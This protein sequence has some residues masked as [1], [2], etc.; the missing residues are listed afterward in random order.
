MTSIN[1]H[2]IFFDAPTPIL[3]GFGAVIGL[4]VGSFV[5]NTA[6]RSVRG[7]SNLPGRSI[8]DQCHVALR[9]HEAV[10]VASF[11]IQRGRC[12][13]CK[14]SISPIHLWGEIA[15]GAAFASAPTLLPTVPALIT[16]IMGSVLLALSLIDIKTLKLPNALVFC[17]LV[18]SALLSAL[19]GEAL[20]S[21][22][23]AAGVFIVLKALQAILQRRSGV[24][25]LGEG[26]I[27]LLAALAMWLG[28]ALVYASSL[29]CMG[30]LLFIVLGKHKGRLPFGPF[31]ALGGFIIGLF[32]ESP[33]L[34]SLFADVWGGGL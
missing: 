11:L 22:L 8:C 16:A 29:A 10:P 7:E 9:W 24:K 30:A 28:P 2:P 21:L 20:T 1:P 18:C 33:I 23:W 17:V 4:V 27:K 26:D 32:V 13:T 15:G 19:R 6:I 34:Q 3:A 14:A 31:I 25:S 5:T 12:R